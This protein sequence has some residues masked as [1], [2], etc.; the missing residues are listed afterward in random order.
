MPQGCGMLQAKR[1]STK[2]HDVKLL[3][4]DKLA[5]ST[6]VQEESAKTDDGQPSAPD[7][8]A[9]STDV[10]EDSVKADDVKPSAPDEPGHSIDEQ[11]PL[12]EQKG[13]DAQDYSGS[14]EAAASPSSLP[15]SPD[16]LDS[17]PAMSPVVQI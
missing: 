3:P 4:P 9:H 5:H 16:T 13:A 17:Y 12:H 11:N 15:L 6:D 8:P 7:E 1:E 10:Q 14:S 2:A